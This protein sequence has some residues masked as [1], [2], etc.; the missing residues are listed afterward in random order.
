MTLSLFFLS[1]LSIFTKSFYFV[2][3]YFVISTDKKNNPMQIDM[4]KILPAIEILFSC[5]G[6]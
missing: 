6:K 1:T 2:K 3:N 5:Y 4:L